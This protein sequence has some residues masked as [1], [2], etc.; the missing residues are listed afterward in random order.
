MAQQIAL[1]I[2]QKNHMHDDVRI[3]SASFLCHYTSHLL[4]HEHDSYSK[5]LD[6]KATVITSKDGKIQ[7]PMSYQDVYGKLFGGDRILDHHQIDSYEG[8]NTEAHDL[9]TDTGVDDDRKDSPRFDSTRLP[10]TVILECHHREIGGKNTTFGDLQSISNLCRD[11]GIALH[12]DG[13]RIWEAAVYYHNDDNYACHGINEEIAADHVGGDIRVEPTEEET[14]HETI[15]RVAS[16]FDSIYVSTYKGLGAMTGSLL[17]G[18]KEF[19]QEARIWLRRFGGIHIL[20]QY[21]TAVE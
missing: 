8:N 11:N 1:M 15:L 20:Q 2:H 18:S 4:I 10:S 17:V 14:M 13:A 12:M 7:Y 3:D 19:I 16:L 9:T 21:Y 5:L 6:M